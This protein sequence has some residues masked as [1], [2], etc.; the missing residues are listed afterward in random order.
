M[1]GKQLKSKDIAQWMQEQSAQKPVLELMEAELQGKLEY[2]QH[3]VKAH[4]I[5]IQYHLK[6]KNQI[7]DAI[8][9]MTTEENQYLQK[10]LINAATNYEKDKMEIVSL[11]KNIEAM[12]LLLNQEEPSSEETKQKIIEILDVSDD[13]MLASTLKKEWL[14]QSKN[15]LGVLF[16]SQYQG[17]KAVAKL[18]SELHI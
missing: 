4:E 12:G 2:M 16:A 7:E 1:Q 11:I 18:Y 17:S 5:L 14:E 9:K 10:I 6:N 15:I 8:S 3:K 13:Q